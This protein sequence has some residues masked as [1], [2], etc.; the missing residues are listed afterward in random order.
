MNYD[1]KTGIELVKLCDAE[2]IKISEVM[3]RREMD[4]SETAREDVI[5]E[6]RSSLHVMRESSEKG[7]TEKVQSV[8]RLSGGEAMKLYSYADAEPLSGS[9]TCKAAAAAMAVVEVNAAMGRIVAAPTAGASGIL[10]GVL[11]ET[12]KARNWS[13]DQLIEGLFCAGAV[14]ML[15][16]KNAT[17][18]GA[19]GGCQAE[20]GVAAA[21]SAAALVEI[22]GG[23]P[24]QCL[25]AAAIAIKNIEGLVC[26]PV[27]GLVECPCI[28]RNAMGAAN[29]MLSADMA[30]CGITSLIPF[31][32]V[33]VSMY[34]VGR[35]IR[36][37]YRETSKGGLAATPTAKLIASGIK[38]MNGR[39]DD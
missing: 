25:D 31:D 14:G 13:D 3:I 38:R 30:L 19:A 5:A 34:N 35:D 2:D 32:E 7:L 16:A 20:T 1:F 6:M 24:M 37:E 28:K 22:S 26:D 15:F 33:V 36:P 10:P 8:S 11:L 17:I 4:I 12:G 9:H 29:A 27:A 18:S 39:R 23:S 21:I